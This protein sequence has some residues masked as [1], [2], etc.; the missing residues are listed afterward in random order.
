MP[1]VEGRV[2]HDADSHIFE[3]PGYAESYADPKI[4][5]ALAGALGRGDAGKFIDLGAGQAE[6]PRVPG[7]G[8]R[9]DHAAQEPRGPRAP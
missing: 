1:Y 4:R 8:R 6:G 5:D 3:P 7:Q 2:V 9:G